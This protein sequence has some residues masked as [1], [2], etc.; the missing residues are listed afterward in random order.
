M[1]VR[2]VADNAQLRPALFYWPTPWLGMQAGA[3]LTKDDRGD[4]V[5]ANVGI[6][7]LLR[8]LAFHL[9]GH[10]GVERWAFELEGPSIASFDAQTTY[11]GSAA[12]LWAIGKSLRLGLSVE[13]ERLR[14]TGAIGHFWCISGGVQY[15]FGVE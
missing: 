9:R 10:A 4:A 14:D 8:P 15:L 12:L 11:G 13:G 7:L 2:R 6:S 3:R 5:S 1:R